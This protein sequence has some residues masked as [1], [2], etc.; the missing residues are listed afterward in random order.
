MRPSAILTPKRSSIIGMVIGLNILQAY[1]FV[2][3]H[4][5]GI[6]NKVADAL[7]RRVTLLSVMSVE[8]TRFK[9]L[10]EKYESYLEFREM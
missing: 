6:E 9:R 2:L 4:K 7:S 1:S 3:K 10:K 5:S 8:L